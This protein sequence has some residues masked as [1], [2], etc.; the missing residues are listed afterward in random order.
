MKTIEESGA[1]AISLTV[2]R[3]DRYEEARQAVQDHRKEHHCQLEAMSHQDG[4]ELAVVTRATHSSYVLEIGPALA[5]SGLQIMSSFGRTGRLD[6]VEPDREHARLMAEWFGRFAAAERA[7]VQTS[8]VADVVPA[9]GGLYD[10]IVVSGSWPEIPGVYEHL[11]RL[12]R[13]GGTLLVRAST[14]T[15]DDDRA[16]LSA[17][18]TRLADDDRVEPWF[19]P[20]LEQVLAT[21]CR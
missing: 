8:T 13:I 19:G 4:R 6:V 3:P 21:R 16:A 20:R 12:A 18:L 15:S 17:L 14:A 1:M 9:L 10:L 11:L 2:K 5:Y 7:R